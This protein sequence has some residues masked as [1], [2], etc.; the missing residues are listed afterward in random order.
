MELIYFTFPFL[1]LTETNKFQERLVATTTINEDEPEEDE[2]A[3]DG[4][5]N[6]EIMEDEEGSGGAEVKVETS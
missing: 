1:F 6:E 4:V 5:D 3:D 2:A